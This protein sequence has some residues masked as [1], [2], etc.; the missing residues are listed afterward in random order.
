MTDPTESRERK[1]RYGGT[2]AVGRGSGQQ[3]GLVRRLGPG[4]FNEST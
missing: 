3:T 4:D 1:D 2:E